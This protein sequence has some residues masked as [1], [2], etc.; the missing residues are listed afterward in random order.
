[1]PGNDIIKTK[2]REIGAEIEQK[3]QRVVRFEDAKTGRQ[4]KRCYIKTAKTGVSIEVIG[5]QKPE[6]NYMIGIAIGKEATTIDGRDSD[7]VRVYL[8]KKIMGQKDQLVGSIDQGAKSFNQSNPRVCPYN[9]SDFEVIWNLIQSDDVVQDAE[10]R[11]VKLF[12]RDFSFE[13]IAERYQ[14]AIEQ[15]DQVLLDLSRRLLEADD[16]DYFIA[17]NHKVTPY[18][19]REHVVP[20]ITI[21]NLII[22][23][24][25]RGADGKTREQNKEMI[26]AILKRHLKLVH[27][28]KDDADKM[29]NNNL[30]TQMPRGWGPDDSPYARLIEHGIAVRNK[31]KKM[32]LEP[33]E[34]RG[35]KLSVEA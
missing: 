12:A 28:H 29:N 25:D 1:M 14:F 26:V 10:T 16:M 13:R 24:I 2:I 19:Y 33:E 34:W 31:K 35:K 4:G 3:I 17:V 30:K 9:L 15:K 8:R 7:A 6:I 5:F 20:C 11:G 32:A 27:I 22:N 21:H 23:Q 18:D